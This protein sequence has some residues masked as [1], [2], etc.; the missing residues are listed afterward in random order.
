MYI[1]LYNGTPTDSG[2][3]AIT[4]SRAKGQVKINSIYIYNEHSGN[5][6]LLMQLVKNNA[7]AVGSPAATDNI[8][9]TAAVATTANL[10]LGETEIGTIVLTEDNDTLVLTGSTT[11][12]VHVIVLGEYV[13]A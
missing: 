5:A 9:T 11:L 4:M 10:I 2:T 13:T 1:E 7:G 12:K 3:V 6:T 8:Y